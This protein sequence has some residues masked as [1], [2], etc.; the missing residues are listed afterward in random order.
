MSIWSGLSCLIYSLKKM[1]ILIPILERQKHLA[2]WLMYAEVSH[3]VPDIVN[4]QKIL[5]KLNSAI[6]DRPRA[7]I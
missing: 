5:R 7:P 1:G 3:T 6:W 2:R 4:I